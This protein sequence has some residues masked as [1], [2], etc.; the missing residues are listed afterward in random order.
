MKRDYNLRYFEMNKNGIASPIT[1]LTL[2]EETAAEHCHNIGYS[3]YDLEL[4]NIGWVLTSGIIEMVRYPKYKENISIITWLSKYF[5]VNGFRE[6]IILDEDGK[7]I[8][9]ARGRWVFY[10]IQKRKPVPIFEDIRLKWG[11]KQETSVEA[12]LDLINQSGDGSLK[13]EFNIFRSDVDSNKHVNNIRYFHFLLE[14]L[15]EEIVDNYYLKVIN[16]KFFEEAKFGEKIQV[17]INDDLG[18]NN[19]LHTMKSGINNKMFA[20]AHTQWMKFN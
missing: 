10:D 12:N 6:N 20:K 5:L 11:V 14:S 15:P 17:Y 9:K 7:I 8:G 16:A 3:L 19:F 13:S 4:Q 1:I 18:N 2:L